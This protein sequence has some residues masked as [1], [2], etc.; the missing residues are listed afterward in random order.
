MAT[1]RS[2]GTKD[3]VKR[4]IEFDNQRNWNFDLGRFR[5]YA[6]ATCRFM[7]LARDK[8]DHQFFGPKDQILARWGIENSSQYRDKCHELLAS[9]NASAGKVECELLEMRGSGDAVHPDDPLGDFKSIV[10]SF[11]CHGGP[12]IRTAIE[13]ARAGKEKNIDWQG[14]AAWDKLSAIRDVLDHLPMP[15]GITATPI[16]VSNTADGPF[17]TDGFRF[18]RKPYHGLAP[19]PF[20]LITALWNARHRSFTLTLRELEGPVWN[21]P[22]VTATDGMLGSARRHANEF[23][24]DKKLP[25]RVSTSKATGDRTAS[26]KRVPQKIRRS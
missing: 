15:K 24:L 21:D 13:L 5:Q 22:S 23:F 25:F 4:A 11:L 17:G 16:G 9:A 14:L 8:G 6:A 2:N 3:L 7:L 10:A 12:E 18:N 1:R 26:L 20:R 19:I